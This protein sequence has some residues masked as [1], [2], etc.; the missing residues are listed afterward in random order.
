MVDSIPLACSR[1][2]IGASFPEELND[3]LEEGQCV[4]LNEFG[5]V[6]GDVMVQCCPSYLP[7]RI[8]ILKAI[9]LPPDHPISKMRN[10]VFFHTPIPVMNRCDL[11]GC[12]C[13][14]IWDQRI[15]S[16]ASK[17]V[18]QVTE[19]CDPPSTKED[20][21]EDDWIKYVSVWENI[22]PI[23][24][25]ETCFFKVVEE[26]GVRSREC[27][28]LRKIYS[29]LLD[30]GVHDLQ[31]TFRN[32]KS[33][34]FGSNVIRFISYRESIIPIWVKMMD[35]QLALF[36]DICERKSSTPFIK[37]WD[38][39]YKKMLDSGGG[40][41][42]CSVFDSKNI[43]ACS[44]EDVRSQIK[45]MWK[46]LNQNSHP[47]LSSPIAES[48][49][50]EKIITAD[51]EFAE[52]TSRDPSLYQWQEK[53]KQLMK[54]EIDVSIDP[55]RKEFMKNLEIVDNQDRLLS[56]AI[57]SHEEEYTRVKNERKKLAQTEEELYQYS[58][59]M[60]RVKYI[61]SGHETRQ[62]QFR[63][64]HV[65]FTTFRKSVENSFTKK[66]LGRERK[67]SDKELEIEKEREELST[68]VESFEKYM[69]RESWLVELFERHSDIVFFSGEMTSYIGLLMDVV[70]KEYDEL[71]IPDINDVLNM[72]SDIQMKLHMCDADID[73]WT[74]MVE[75]TENTKSILEENFEEL[76]K[77]KDQLQCLLEND[78]PVLSRENNG[79][80]LAKDNSHLTTSDLENIE[81]EK[82]ELTTQNDQNE[83]LL[84]S[85][86][87]KLDASHNER[88][89][90]QEEELSSY[91]NQVRS[92][93]V[94]RMIEVSSKAEVFNRR[95]CAFLDKLNVESRSMTVLKEEE[96]AKL[97]A[98]LELCL[99][100][101]KTAE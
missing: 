49:E 95:S 82:M 62:L 4:V 78:D 27:T 9:T 28:K 22:N 26:K 7:G 76:T 80:G 24:Q 67:K 85:L 96:I 98:E 93:A 42:M 84:S 63:Q 94:Q 86:K 70:R 79:Q 10:V 19:N 89:S 18:D 33:E 69:E 3:F 64:F 46:R 43:V 72:H 47:I 101:L 20:K 81:S 11:N 91:N 39:F 97:D 90:L 36:R 13:L 88:H 56:T 41:E 48:E 99:N 35:K 59:D 45:A 17:F 87:E 65:N 37:D 16:F 31:Q 57:S 92:K 66:F 30:L 5:F 40:S 44:T 50:V 2:L 8:Q 83:T 14:V 74:E 29:T 100:R 34:L 52:N 68:L 75:K 58:D 23:A 55:L 38:L 25:L 61:I 71:K 51:G 60:H 53:W 12:S 54:S 21:P 73:R 32:L 6:E 1:V 15:L 77:R